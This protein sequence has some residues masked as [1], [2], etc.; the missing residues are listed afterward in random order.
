MIKEINFIKEVHFYEAVEALGA[1]NT[2]SPI[3]FIPKYYGVLQSTETDGRR[4]SYIA[5]ENLSRN[6]K[7]PCVMDIKIGRQTFEPTVSEKK[8]QRNISKYIFQ[9]EVG[10]RV[11]GFKTFM[12]TDG[13]YTNVEKSFGRSLKPEQV[14]NGLKKFFWNGVR[15]RK[16]VVRV[17]LAKLEPLWQWAKRQQV[18]ELYCSSVLISYDG[19]SAYDAPEDKQVSV[20]IIDFAHTLLRP[21]DNQRNDEGY[22]F[23]IQ[24][25]IK[26]LELVLEDP[27]DFCEISLCE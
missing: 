1:H 10:F 8:K 12:E 24:N 2:Q 22:A 7:K 9:H 27:T 15:V 26:H 6:L 23:G 4:S 11:T 3:T 20:K 14:K 13:S 16:D 25:L 18:F 21:K 5:L 19:G 17:V